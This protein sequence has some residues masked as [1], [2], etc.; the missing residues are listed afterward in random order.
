MSERDGGVSIV[1]DGAGRRVPAGVTVAAALIN[2]G[3][4][5]MRRSVTG[6]ARGPLCGMGVC[7]ECRV[8]V[9]G[10]DG[11]RACLERV[12]DGMRVETMRSGSG[13]SADRRVTEMAPATCLEADV[14]IVGSGP[15]GIAA[16][17][18][19]AERGRRVIVIDQ[20]RA[21][22]GQ[23]WRQRLG[24]GAP[25]AAAPWLPRLAAA[26]EI[27]VLNG[28]SVIDAEIREGGVLLRAIRNDRALQIISP[29]IVLATGARERFIPFPGWTLPGVIGVGAAQALLAGGMTV[30]GLRV[31]VAGSGPLLLP[32]AAALT[33]AGARVLEVA[34]QASPRRVRGFGASLWRRPDLVMQ[35]LKYRAA[36]RGTPYRTGTWVTRAASGHDAP[37]G[38]SRPDDDAALQ[39]D[40]MLHTHSNRRLQSVQVTNGATTRTVECELLCTGYGLVPDTRLARL[41]GCATSDDDDGAVVVDG[42]QATSIAGVYCAGESTGVGGVGLALAEG[43]I[44][45]AMAAGSGE[46]PARTVRSRAAFAR[47]ASEMARAFAPRA[48][49]REIATDETIVCRCEDVTLASCRLAH[50]AR[51]AKLTTR[52]GMG[53]CQGRVCGP[54]LRSVTG[55]SADRVRPPIEPTPVRL[56]F[57]DLAPGAALPSTRTNPHAAR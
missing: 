41:L 20:G 13:A 6:E 56:L 23:I 29:R 14:A 40:S 38:R 22:G 42:A 52:A 43:E 9:N 44:A 55:W 57:D 26:R 3:D 48:E 34:E 27:S 1:V 32:V 25:R 39:V 31:V 54:A 11:R 28:A 53:A 10:H 5:A 46:A 24:G 16:A 8:R 19:A 37:A 45:G 30:R 4:W 33:A 17:I 18:A 47:V 15:A 50:S 21:P 12:A 49:V 51:E 7:F 2:A 35:G 36:F